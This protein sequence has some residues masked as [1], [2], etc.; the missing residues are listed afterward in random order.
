MTETD[1]DTSMHARR[2]ILFAIA[3]VLF[4]GTLTPADAR[5]D[6]S[7]KWVAN[8]EKSNFGSISSPKNFTREITHDDLHVVIA[9]QLDETASVES[10]EL[11]LTTDGDETVSRIGEVDVVGYARWLGDHLLVHTSRESQGMTLVID[12]LWTISADGEIL[13]IDANVITPMGEQ[14][15][16]VIFERR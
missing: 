4:P 3:F 2:A 12:E 7:G 10:G 15:L 5:P 13:Q 8:L 11:R 14:E 16:Q 1:G 9:V 6:F